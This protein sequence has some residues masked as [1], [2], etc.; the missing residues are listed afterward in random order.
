MN[1]DK[2][3]I[4]RLEEIKGLLSKNVD[5]KLINERSD[6]EFSLNKKNINFTL[7]GNNK[8]YYANQCAEFTK[9]LEKFGF[10]FWISKGMIKRN[11]VCFNKYSINNG[12]S[13]Y[14]RD[15]KRFSSKEEM[16]GFVIG[17][18]ESFINIKEKVV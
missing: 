5:L 4:N 10:G 13:Q 2:K 3:Q 15:I 14:C 16:I 9:N 8:Y 7:K 11:G 1:Q 6:I 18:N 12:Y 17:Y